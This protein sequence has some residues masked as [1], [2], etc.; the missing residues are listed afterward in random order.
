[1]GRPVIPVEYC[2]TLGTPGDFILADFSQYVLG[3]KGGIQ[4]ASSIHVRFINDEMTYRFVMRVDGQSL[5]KKPLTP[6][7]GTNTYSPFV[8]L[9][10]RP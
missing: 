3:E 5:W 8:V 7:N 4:T 1:L 2:A 6:K 10:T 9:A